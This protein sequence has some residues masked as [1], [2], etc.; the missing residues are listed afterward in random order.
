MKIKTHIWRKVLEIGLIITLMTIGVAL[1]PSAD[2]L[3][4]IV[5]LI[6]YIQSFF[7]IG[8]FTSL[9]G[10]L[11]LVSHCKTDREIKLNFGRALYL[12]SLVGIATVLLTQGL[13]LRIITSIQFLISVLIFLLGFYLSWTT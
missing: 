1:H 10:A 11:G 12:P 5:H 6:P 8:V 4:Q 3:E 9:I 7:M 2:Y 13:V